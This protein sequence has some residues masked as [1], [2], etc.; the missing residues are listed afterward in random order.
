[1]LKFNFVAV[2]KPSS[3]KKAMFCFVH[4]KTDFIEASVPL[5]VTCL[6]EVLEV[7]EIESLKEKVINA[8]GSQDNGQNAPDLVVQL[9]GKKVGSLSFVVLE[10]IASINA[11]K[12]YLR[13]GMR[14]NRLLKREKCEYVNVSFAWDLEAE[15]YLSLIEGMLLDDYRFDNYRSKGNTK[16]PEDN[17]NN[18]NKNDSVSTRT[19]TSINIE[20]PNSKIRKA[21][22]QHFEY[23]ETLANAT[24]VARDLINM[25]PCDCTPSYLADFCKK[26]FRGTRVAVKV[27]DAKSL[28]AMGAKAILAVG[29]GSTIKPLVVRLSL[30]PAVASKTTQQKLKKVALIGKGVTFDSGG[31]SIKPADSMELMKFDMAGGAA[32]IGAMVAL[33]GLTSEYEPKCEVVAYIPAVENVISGAA[34]KPGDVVKSLSGKFIEILNTDAEGRLILADAIALAQVEEA[35]GIVDVATL[36]GAC[37]VALG[38]KVA[39]AFSRDAALIEALVAAGNASGELFWQLPL[40]DEYKE[41]LKSTIG[42]IKNISGGRWGGAITAAL[43]L[44]E[45]ITCQHWLHLDIAGPAY[46][47]KEGVDCAQGGVGFGVRS[48]VRLVQNLQ[49]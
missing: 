23:T 26:V 36:T 27:Y 41:S 4:Q 20:I 22:E 2:Q 45:F 12:E 29:A 25:P 24:H 8:F 31:L 43:F 11:S 3:K 15:H 30:K 21:V 35:Q 14:I 9:L 13:L 16:S 6:K 40:V 33:A 44:E 39:G 42:D 17:K 46:S 38:G 7:G 28:E 32:V 48:L 37:M 49:L 18:S 1:M 47:E 10:K 34:V 19:E 5:N